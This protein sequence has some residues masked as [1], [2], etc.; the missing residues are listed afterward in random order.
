MKKI[1]LLTLVC[2]VLNISLYAERIEWH[3]DL[4]KAKSLALET[5]KP[6]L[7]DFT[8][9]W[10]G[11]CK[12]MDQTFWVRSDVIEF[13]KRFICVKVDFDRSSKLKSKYKIKAIPF[14]IA[15]DPWGM[16]IASERGF[17][18][19]GRRLMMR[20]K[21][22]PTDFSDIRPF[23]NVLET[24]KKNI[25]ALKGI[26]EFYQSKK[27]YYSS[28]V[29]LKQL[30]KNSEDFTKREGLMIKYGFNYLRLGMHKKA[31]GAFKKFVK[32]FPESKS[33][34][35]ILYGQVIMHTQKKKMKKAKK[36]L[37]ELN[38]RFPESK[39]VGFARNT[40]AKVRK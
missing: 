31:G 25:H 12:A 20:L 15:T 22:V 8:A 7:L 5:G 18:G 24:D 30:F 21:Y 37:V 2:G 1:L 35:R 28:N 39:Y 17:D 10:C 38:S 14:V 33:M 6:M 19:T 32:R 40:I 9:E 26:I 4:K 27:L 11:P 34:D 29:F 13:S 36:V 16:E 23:K 3:Y